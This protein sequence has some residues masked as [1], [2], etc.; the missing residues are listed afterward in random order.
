MYM[1]LDSLSCTVETISTFHCSNCAAIK[2]R[3]K[4]KRGVSR[5]LGG[6]EWWVGAGTYMRC[7]DPGRHLER[8]LY[9]EL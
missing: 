6:K 1:H 5:I 2:I 3:Q 4:E 9:D 8:T 7:R